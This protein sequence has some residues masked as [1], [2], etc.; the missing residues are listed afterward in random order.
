[1]ALPKL[2]QPIF[3]ITLPSSGKKLRYRQFTVRE[4]K[5]LLT[6][7]SSN[8]KSDMIDAFKQLINNCCLDEIDVDSM[9]ALDVEYFFI[10]LR[11]K[12]VSNVI[13]LKIEEDGKK[14]EMEMNLDNVKVS[15]PTVENKLILDET[16]GVGVI[17][18]YPT[19]SMLKRMSELDKKDINSSLEVFRMVIETVFDADGVYPTDDTDKADFED[20]VMSFT[21]QQVAYVEKFLDDMPYVYVD[22][23]YTIGGVT[24][25]HRVR[26][27]E[28]FFA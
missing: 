9:S 18:R 13:K 3:N 19:F 25:T 14:Y 1:M 8:E 27:I 16:R 26:G 4:E 12:S 2:N 5:I 7:Q 10:Q 20:F 17:L 24:H 15:K 21:N 11:A 22:V 28:N 23:E 6:A